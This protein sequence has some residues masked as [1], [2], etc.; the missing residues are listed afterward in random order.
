M[1]LRKFKHAFT[2]FLMKSLAGLAPSPAY[3]AYA[4]SGSAAELCRHITRTGVR[5]LLL[6]TDKPL[7]DLGIVDQ[8]TAALADTGVEIVIFDGVEPNPTYDQVAAGRKLMV[9][10]GC[11]AVLAIG[12]GSS[13]DAAKII[14]AS[15][16]SEEDPKTWVGFGKVKHEVPKLYAI[17][18]TSGT[19]S[20]ATM[21]AVISDSESREK[22]VISGAS[23]LPAAVALDS[24]LM[25]GMPAPITAATGIDALT[26]AI[27]AYICVWDRGTRKEHAAMATRLVFR[28]LRDAV[29]D[30]GNREARDGMAMAAYYAGIAINQVNVG[31]VHAIA[32]QI[33][34]K[35]GIP[36]GLA[37]AL[38]LP[39]VLEFCRA[40]SGEALAELALLVEAGSAGEST[41]ALAGKFIDAVVQLRADVGLPA[42]SDRIRAEDYDYLAGLAFKECEGYPV[43][44]LLER[45][46]I[47]D[48][49][50][51]ITA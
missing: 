41:D 11:E 16:S 24:D 5:K 50:R 40:E 9:E 14:A 1:S 27:E 21:G 43:P 48:I 36:H 34:G 49:L 32:H 31:N 35:Y 30:G 4:G 2:L 10:H 33:G 13:I 47:L 18:T 51:K 3:M 28:H 7:R 8:A 46:A 29:A 26:H 38:V 19:G 20:E 15:A 42:T 39:H 6:V 37:N 45:D 25:L 17:P 23:L 22:G 44:K 12:G